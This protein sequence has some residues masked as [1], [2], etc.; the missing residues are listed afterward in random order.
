VGYYPLVTE[1]RCISSGKF[2]SLR[3][4]MWWQNDNNIG[5]V[6]FSFFSLRCIRAIK[7]KRF[8]MSP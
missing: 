5:D 6:F 8:G 2:E 3:Q 4:G 7:K 1:V